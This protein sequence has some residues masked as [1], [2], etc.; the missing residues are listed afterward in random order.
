MSESIE[1]GNSLISREE[2]T[3]FKGFLILL[4]IVGHNMF[5]TYH[6]ENIQAMGYLYNFHIEA[7]F[8]IPFLYGGRKLTITRILNGFVRLYWPYILLT[9]LFYIGF[10]IIYSC[11]PFDLG[12][13][14]SL[15]LYPNSYQ[16]HIYTGVQILWFLPTMYILTLLKDIYYY[17][18]NAVRICLMILSIIIIGQPILSYFIGPIIRPL[19]QMLT[20]IPCGFR[21]A[22]SFF[23]WGISIRYLLVKIDEGKIPGWLL[24]T[25]WILL[26]ASYFIN[27]LIWKNNFVTFSLRLVFPFVFFFIYIKYRKV[28]MTKIFHH[29]GS[30]SFKIYLIHPFLGYVLFFLL[31]DFMNY[32]IFLKW[33]IIISSIIVITLISYWLA[34]IITRFRP[35]DRFFFP[36]NFKDL[37][38]L[39][40]KRA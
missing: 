37:Q 12:R 6:T 38:L 29:L 19:I 26:T 15:W 36:R 20:Y 32:N 16:L 14:M 1:H 17:S 25:S 39:K 34:K 30:H 31:P 33:V 40:N 8:I 22:M 27:I 3:A 23:L 9:T 18:H 35:F 10:Y 2:S 4:I 21:A 13:L 28:I 5:F 24:F 7:F 11:H